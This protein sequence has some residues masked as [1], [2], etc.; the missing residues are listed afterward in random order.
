[1]Y[2]DKKRRRWPVALAGVLTAIL[3]TFGF[4]LFAGGSG[5]DAREDGARALKAAIQ[6]AALQCYVV[7]GVYPPGLEYMEEH[8][9]LQINREDYYVTYNAFASN[10]P[11]EVTVVSK[12][13]N[14]GG[15]FF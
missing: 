4:W 11:P 7:E 3:L 1:M 6:S 15:R 12:P 8:Y 5:R 2:T 14:K 13:G 9:G 10:L